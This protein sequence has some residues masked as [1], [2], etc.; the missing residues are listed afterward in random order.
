MRLL[1]SELSP[2][3]DKQV[4]NITTEKDGKIYYCFETVEGKLLVGDSKFISECSEF[5]LL[6]IKDN[7][8]L[9]QK[10]MFKNCIKL[11]KTN[12]IYNNINEE[13]RESAIR[14]AILHCL[15]TH[16]LELNENTIIVLTYNPDMSTLECKI[17]NSDQAIPLN[18]DLYTG[19][20]KFIN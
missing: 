2:A 6:E 18:Q 14:K 8:I 19:K 20:Y 13:S 3:I 17:N 16:N 15:N 1:I 9:K 11:K 5:K 10:P 12:I 4:G 7:L